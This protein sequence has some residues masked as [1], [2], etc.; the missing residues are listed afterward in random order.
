MNH[1]TTDRRSSLS[2]SVLQIRMPQDRSASLQPGLTSEYH[3]QKHE[4]VAEVETECH[5]TS[6]GLYERR[7][8]ANLEWLNLADNI[9]N[10]GTLY[11]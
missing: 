9:C 11:E 4:Y 7:A 3:K 1:E 5:Q 8:L 6:R 10:S 2:H